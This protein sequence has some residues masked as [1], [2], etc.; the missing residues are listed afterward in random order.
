L[1]AGKTEISDSAIFIHH[2]A[3][4]WSEVS[5]GQG[6]RGNGG[7]EGHSFLAG[8]IR[9]NSTLIARKDGLRTGLG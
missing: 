8:S 2:P 4:T 1:D 3:K 5:L 6:D 9:N 7:K